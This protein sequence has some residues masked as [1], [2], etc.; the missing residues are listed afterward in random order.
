MV[1]APF[2]VVL[3]AEM[4]F[5]FTVRD[6]LLG[7]AALERAR[8]PLQSPSDE[9]TKWAVDLP[10]EHSASSVRRVNLRLLQA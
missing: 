9:V 1:P 3:D 10:I 2:R 7:A 6:A 5:P 8:R 4:L